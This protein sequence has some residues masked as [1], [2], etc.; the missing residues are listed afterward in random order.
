MP[1]YRSLP[2]QNPG[3]LSCAGG[4]S[5]FDRIRWMTRLETLKRDLE[6]LRDSL[7]LDSQELQRASPEERKTI[8]EHMKWCADEMATLRGMFGDT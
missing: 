3:A 4:F 8:L 1:P 6:T 7:K 5:S 2:F